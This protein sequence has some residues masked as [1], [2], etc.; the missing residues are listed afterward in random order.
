MEIQKPEWHAVK[1]C[2]CGV[3]DDGW[4]TLVA[5]KG[6]GR[7][8]GCCDETDVL[9]A[10]PTDP[11]PSQPMEPDDVCD[12]CGAALRDAEPATSEEIQ[13]EGLRWKVDYE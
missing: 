8:F 11:D 3:C 5:C 1:R 7:V 6:C 4:L 12:T 9:F 13:K 10:D 2:P